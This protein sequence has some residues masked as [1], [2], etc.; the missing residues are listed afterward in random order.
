MKFFLFFILTF[1]NYVLLSQND[2]IIVSHES[3]YHDKFVLKAYSNFGQLVYEIN[4]KSA[5]T[6]SKNWNDSLQIDKSTIIS[7]G[8]KIN[9]KIVNEKT[10]FYLI[11]YSSTFPVLSISIDEKDLYDPYKGIYVR[12]AR[13]YRDS[14][15]NRLKNA[16]FIKKWERK[17]NIIYIDENG[18][19]VINQSAGLRI[20]GGMTRYRS[21]K[22]LRIIAR[23]IYGKNRFNYPFFKYRNNG[24][25][26]HLVIRNSGG[27]AYKTRFRDVLSTQISKQLD[28]DIQEFQPINLFVNG[29]LWGVYNLRE[30]IGQHYLNY[31]FNANIDSLNLLQGRYTEDHGSNNSYKKLRSF[32]IN[33]NLDN[34]KSVDSLKKMIDLRNFINFNAA[35]IY[36]CNTDYRGNIRFWQHSE[37]EKFRWIMYDTDLGFIRP[38]YN[39]LKDRLSDT[40]TKW[41][42][43][44]WS[45]LLLRKILKNQ[46][47]KNDFIN[48]VCHS[49]STSFHPENVNRAIDSL[50]RIYRPELIKHFKYVKGDLKK[51]EK[52]VE[53]LRDFANQRSNSFLTHLKKEFSIENDFN[54]NIKIDS[55]KHGCVT[56]NQNNIYK[57][58]YTGFFFSEIPIPF[59][60]S[61]KPL[62]RPIISINGKSKAYKKIKLHN[63]IRDTIINVNKETQNINIS[64]K[65]VGDSHWKDKIKINEVGGLGIYDTNKW[66]EL[67]SEKKEE[68]ILKNWKLIFSKGETDIKNITFNMLKVID[69]S[70]DLIDKNNRQFI[71]LLDNKSKLVDSITWENNFSN[72]VFHVQK[73]LP[74]INTISVE[75]GIGTP[76]SLNPKHLLLIEEKKKEELGKIVAIF[77]TFFVLIFV[78]FSLGRENPKASV[79]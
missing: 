65:Y 18:R 4:G 20:F 5:Q 69:F 13:S 26:K 32:V 16:N 10:F 50:E 25:Y 8:L 63:S 45:T 78:N 51:W 2:S 36:L 42:N 70:G 19:E 62:Y 22:S 58:E 68:I 37:K 61:F 55:L 24:E 11:D 60:V 7:L 34:K 23:G 53:L 67:Y 6:K 64:Y 27:D 15:E 28:I 57:N 31:N 59:E 30:R 76:N 12:G 47:I 74:S 75:E 73:T 38:N 56:I 41:H 72:K 14:V 35:Q 52:N 40:E 79:G 71:Y 1:S 17:C 3:G 46:Q 9:N 33:N 43:P 21:E 49:L 66:I 44:K 54:L 77:F 29:E 48:Q 39:F